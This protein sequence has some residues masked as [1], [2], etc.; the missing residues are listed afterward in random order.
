[1]MWY[2]KKGLN[3]KSCYSTQAVESCSLNWPYAKR[4]LHVQRTEYLNIEFQLKN[5]TELKKFTY[6]TEPIKI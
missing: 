3:A 6:I 1:M 4:P 5:V 2:A